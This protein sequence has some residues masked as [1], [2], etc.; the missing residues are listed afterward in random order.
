MGAV[1]G[2]TRLVLTWV[3]TAPPCGEVEEN[4]A[5]KIITEVHYL[6]F[7]IIIYAITFAVVLIGSVLTKPRAPEK[8]KI[9]M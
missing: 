1:I 8:V 7:A 4:P 5:W 3:H 2:L 6:H 9:E